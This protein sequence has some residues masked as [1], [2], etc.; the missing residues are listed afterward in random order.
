MNRSRLIAVAVL[1]IA[2][3]WTVWLLRLGDTAGTATP[4][5]QRHLIKPPSASSGKVTPGDTFT[6]AYNGDTVTL[7][8]AQVRRSHSHLLREQT[9]SSADGDA[10]LTTAS[11]PDPAF[12]F[13]SWP[14]R[15]FL[16]EE[17]IQTRR[18]WVVDFKNPAPDSG[19]S[20][21]GTVRIFVDKQL[22]A[23]MRMTAYDAAGKRVLNY[24]VISGNRV[25]GALAVGEAE[26]LHYEPG[27]SHVVQEVTYRMP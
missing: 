23:L 7:D 14:G 13:L 24:A 17:T 9:T 22:G 11:A 27:T 25:N 8:L 12:D 4:A 19:D 3:G 21:Y 16:G 20:P 6:F 15:H 18:C 5:V 1:M 2:A 10:K 26:A